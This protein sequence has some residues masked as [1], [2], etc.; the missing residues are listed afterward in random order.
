[1]PFSGIISDIICSGK[2]AVN[3]SLYLNPTFALTSKYDFKVAVPSIYAGSK[4]LA[5]QHKKRLAPAN[6]F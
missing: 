4:I 1:L 5:R 2:K 6:H 3:R